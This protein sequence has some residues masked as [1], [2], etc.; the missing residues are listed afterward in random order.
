MTIWS[1]S[2]LY[3]ILFSGRLNPKLFEIQKDLWKFTF[4]WLNLWHF[5]KSLS[6]YSTKFYTHLDNQTQHIHLKSLMHWLDLVWWRHHT[7][8]K[9]VV[10]YN[11]IIKFGWKFFF[12]SLLAWD[13]CDQ[14]EPQIIWSWFWGWAK[15]PFNKLVL[16]K[17]NSISKCQKIIPRFMCDVNLPKFF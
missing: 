9:L 15:E 10:A 2:L 6:V 11:F 8:W 14:K 4:V 5:A 12:L 7:K 13:N 16:R 17:N 1:T 3:V